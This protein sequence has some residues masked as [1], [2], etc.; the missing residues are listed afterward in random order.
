MKIITYQD[1]IKE[2]P[3]T[4]IRKIDE[5]CSFCGNVRHNELFYKLQITVSRNYG[6]K[7]NTDRYHAFYLCATRPCGDDLRYIGQY[8][9]LGKL[10]LEEALLELKNNPL[11]IEE[12][13]NDI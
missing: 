7:E 3:A 12:M 9:G 5:C 11:V 2:L 4:F 6:I 8:A 10:T 13:K 1:I